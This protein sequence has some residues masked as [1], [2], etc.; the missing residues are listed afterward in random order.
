MKFRTAT[1]L[2]IMATPQSNSTSCGSL[3][4]APRTR[5]K[6]S[7]VWQKKQAWA[8]KP[9]VSSRPASIFL[10]RFVLLLA[11]LGAFVSFA[12]DV[13]VYDSVVSLATNGTKNYTFTD[14]GTGQSVTIAVTMSP[15]SSDPPAV[16]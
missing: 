3:G 9:R 7:V 10:G 11:L 6:I 8:L 16:F 14:P 1:T 13:T 5:E 2:K 12:A 4:R 15:S